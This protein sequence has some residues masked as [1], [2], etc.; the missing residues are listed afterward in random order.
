M[1]PM[2]S[3]YVL[4][5]SFLEVSPIE[6]SVDVFKDFRRN[7]VLAVET[8]EFDNILDG[9][10]F[11]DNSGSVVEIEVRLNVIR[12]LSRS[13]TQATQLVREAAEA[14]GLHIVDSCKA[15]AGRIG[16]Y[17]EEGSHLVSA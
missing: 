6:N 14:S 3:R 7:I 11:Y 2:V 5:N 8:G 10:A 12:P 1:K 13:I 15:E 4:T 16:A 17:A 9:T